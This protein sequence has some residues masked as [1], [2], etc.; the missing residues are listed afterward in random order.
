MQHSALLMVMV[1]ESRSYIVELQKI[2]LNEIT[3]F[4]FAEVIRQ[5]NPI[6]DSWTNISQFQLHDRCYKT[7]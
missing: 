5:V 7:R 6:W 4:D 3:Q 1:L 2:H